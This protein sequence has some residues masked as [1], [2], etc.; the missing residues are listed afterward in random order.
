MT[1]W[2]ADD[3]RPPRWPAPLRA[4]LWTLW[5]LVMALGVVLVLALFGVP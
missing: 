2:G 4:V 5:G 3:E 1:V